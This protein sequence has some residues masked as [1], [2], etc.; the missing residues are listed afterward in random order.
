MKLEI[1]FWLPKQIAQG[2]TEQRKDLIKISESLST[3]T[4]NYC[5]LQSDALGFSG[6]LETLIFFAYSAGKNA[7]NH[8]SSMPQTENKVSEK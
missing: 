2:I 6:K 1:N 5:T 8:A 7:Q 3:P 4:E